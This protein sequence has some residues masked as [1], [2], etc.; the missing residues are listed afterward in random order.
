MTDRFFY[1]DAHDGSQRDTPA[2]VDPPP[3]TAMT[4]GVPYGS[5]QTPVEVADW[6]LALGYRL[7]PCTDEVRGH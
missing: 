5:G 3:T 2:V 7:A 1:T 4:D 6:L